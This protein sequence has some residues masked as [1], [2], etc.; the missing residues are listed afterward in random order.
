MESN[1]NLKNGNDIKLEIPTEGGLSQRKKAILL[2]TFIIGIPLS[3]PTIFPLGLICLAI[4]LFQK[5]KKIN[6][7]ALVL[8][9]IQILILIV[10]T[11]VMF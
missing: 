4:L 6:L 7:L 1:K 5:N 11:A 9:L 8:I 10:F 2:I 3:Y